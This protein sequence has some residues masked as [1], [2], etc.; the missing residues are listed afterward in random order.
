MSFNSPKDWSYYDE[1][2]YQDYMTF[3]ND[4]SDKEPAQSIENWSW[5][6]VGDEEEY[7]YAYLD[8]EDEDE[9]WSDDDEDEDEDWSDDDE[10]EDE[11]DW[12]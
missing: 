2:M 1:Y 6:V 7:E 10:D 9:D 3:K 12:Y 11:E 5:S 8:D 4:E